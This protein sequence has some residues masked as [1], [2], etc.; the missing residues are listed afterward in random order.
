MSPTVFGSIFEG[1]LSHDHRR[2]NGQHFTSPE[3]IHKV[4]DP[5]FLDGLKAEF[6]EA[7]AKPVAGGARTVRSRTCIR[8][9]AASPSSTRPQVPATSSPKAISA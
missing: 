1:A 7:C 4:I 5:L 6:E 3:N 8:R 2:A 9:S